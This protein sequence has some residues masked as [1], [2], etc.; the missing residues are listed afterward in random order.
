MEY[1]RLGRTGLMVSCTSFGALPIQR[2]S[3]EESAALLRKALDSGVNYIDT[4]NQYTDSEEKIGAALVGVPRDSYIIS[5]KSGANTYEG[6]LAHI[7]LSLKHLRTDY[8]DILQLHN[9]NPLPDPDDPHGTYAALVEAKRRGWI[10]FLGI[11]NHGMT[12]AKAAVESGKYDTLQYPFCVLATPEDEALVKLCAEK[13]VGFIAMKGMSGGLIRDAKAAWVFMRRYPNVVPIWG[14]QRMEELEE[15]L[16]YAEN[17]P[18]DDE[19]V[20]AAIERERKELSGDFCRGCGYCLPC[21]AGIEIPNSARRKFFLMRSP[22]PAQMTETAKNV[23]LKIE[24]C[25]HC[26]LCASR[27]PYHLDTPKLL[28]ENLAFYMD[29]YRKYHQK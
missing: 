5:S 10:R 28:A 14:V 25:R 17:P 9:P 6:V 26:N 29:F 16:S 21:P 8:I 7:E 20:A 4:A 13:D 18:T 24:N 27:C 1:V 3:F 2:V 12:R 23:M 22:V 19:T 11:T 15:F